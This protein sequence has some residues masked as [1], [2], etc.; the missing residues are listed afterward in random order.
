MSSIPLL[1]GVPNLNL[2]KCLRVCPVTLTLQ[3]SRIFVK[4]SNLSGK[5]RKR[6][7]MP[8]RCPYFYSCFGVSFESRDRF[9]DAGI[10]LVLSLRVVAELDEE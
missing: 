8:E 5:S 9:P 3:S 4:S 10:M 7:P 6:F 2:E 1:L